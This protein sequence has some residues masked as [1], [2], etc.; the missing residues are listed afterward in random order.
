[1]MTHAGRFAGIWRLQKIFRGGKFFDNHAI[2][3]K[4]VPECR[5]EIAIV[6]DDEYQRRDMFE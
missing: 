5:T 1:M 4:K 2:D 3:F 6:F